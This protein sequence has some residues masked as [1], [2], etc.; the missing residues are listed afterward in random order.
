MYKIVYKFC[1]KFRKNTQSTLK[2][3]FKQTLTTNKYMTKPKILSPASNWP[4][5]RAAVQ[6]GCDEIYFGVKELNMRV[7]AK[8]FETSELKKIVSFC[9]ENNVKANLCINTIIYDNELEKINQILTNAKEAN[10]DSIICWDFSVIK[11]CSKLKIPTHISTQASISN[12]ESVKH[13]AKLGA[14]RIILARELNLEQIKEIKNKIHKHKLNIEIECFI[15][16]AMCVAISGRCFMSHQL[17]NKSAN[18]GECIQPCRREYHVKE[19]REPN[20]KDHNCKEHNSK[21]HS[22]KDIDKEFNLEL[23]TDYV[24]SPQDHC[25]IPFLEQLT[26]TIDILKIEGRGRSPEY[27]KATTESYK[28]ALDKIDKNEFSDQTKKELLEKLKTVYNRGFSSGF[29]LGKP[30]NAWCDVY[31]SKA[32]K[33]KEFIGYVR[34]YYKKPKVAEIQIQAEDLKLGDTIMIQGNKSGVFEQKIESMQKNN[35]NIK[36]SKK[37]D[38][39]GIKLNN[40]ARPNDKVFRI[41]KKKN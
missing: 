25:T 21:E 38:R 18:R 14:T 34:N 27:V 8:N 3:V 24:M 36:D 4:M 6:A 11:Q 9:H 26:D 16:G 22:I 30:I 5:L 23:G 32:T 2:K 10:I 20:S 37:G 39:V 40:E 19:N 12:F 1:V 13:F 29:F 33:K 35:N 15:H 7:T 41:I 28:T 17:F 31:G